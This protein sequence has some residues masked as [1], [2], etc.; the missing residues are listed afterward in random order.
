LPG[1]PDVSRGRFLQKES[2]LAEIGLSPDSLIFSRKIVQIY[3]FVNFYLKKVGK[4]G[5]FRLQVQVE[6]ILKGLSFGNSHW[7]LRELER[8]VI[9]Q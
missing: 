5:G 8:A 4:G 6:S 3:F 1:R 9:G 7:S 2:P